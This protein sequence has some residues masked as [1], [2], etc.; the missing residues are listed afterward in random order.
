MPWVDA[1]VV[2]YRR[3]HRLAA[4][5]RTLVDGADGMLARL[6]VIANELDLETV[7]T[8]SACIQIPIVVVSNRQNLGNAHARNQGFYLSGIPHHYV[9]EHP[10]EYICFAEDDIECEPGWLAAE[11]R[12][13]ELF[14]HL[15]IGLV[16]GY[17]S[18]L[19]RKVATHDKEGVRIHL[20]EFVTSQQIL[21]RRDVLDPIFP[22][23]HRP[24]P[25]FPEGSMAPSRGD[26]WIAIDSP[27]SLLKR[28]LCCAVLPGLVRHA[29]AAE[30]SWDP[31]AV[32]EYADQRAETFVPGFDPA[33][34]K[35]AW[36]NEED[37]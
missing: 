19:Q 7:R 24:P 36:M 11:L 1:V 8:A 15:P 9:G 28:G 5:L 25:G 16:T 37:L 23:P 20:K 32:H 29:G 33:T 18:P 26:G 14:S 17:H 34:W 4:A 35:P 10:S 31:S 6:F 2:T 13:F 30:S 3:P 21:A 27:F 22:I 12:V